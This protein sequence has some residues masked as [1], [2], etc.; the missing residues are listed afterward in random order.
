MF[1]RASL[2]AMAKVVS[3]LTCAVVAIAA[4]A[5]QSPLVAGL[6]VVFV[7][8]SWAWS[9]RGYAIA[10]GCIVV[11]RMMGD[12]RIPLASIR[13]ARR[14]GGSDLDGCIRVFGNGGLFGY[15]GLFQT[16]RLG[17]CTWY[18]T[19]R[20]RAVVLVT[21]TKTL[22]LSPDDVDGFLRMIPVSAA[23]PSA[24]SVS[25]VPRR[26]G[27][28]GKV[29]G[30]GIA[31][32]VVGVVAFAF[33]YAPGPPEYTLTAQSLTIHD[34][35]YPVT[36]A[37]SAVDIGGI[38]VVD[39]ATDPAWHPVAKT[40]GFANSHYR[41]GRFRVASGAVV[42]LYAADARRVVLLPPKGQGTAVLLETADPEAFAAKVK[43]AWTS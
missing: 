43:A 42:R 8:L 7:A 33:L 25:G 35:F 2:D 37:S 32:V 21:D 16:T 5:T 10:D 9:T 1:F 34:R 28:A 29:I 23:G 4:L 22:V 40:N 6:G 39:L 3:A 30:G 12:V 41:S 19:T 38:R 31:A 14:A 20:E 36:L 26:S 13:E 24:A 15:Y 11:Q 27:V 17:R 18:V